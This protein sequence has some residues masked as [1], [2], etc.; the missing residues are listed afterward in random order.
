MIAPERTENL[1]WENPTPS[2]RRG[3]F[4]LIPWL[5][6]GA[7][8]LRVNSGLDR[9]TV[10]LYYGLLT[11]GSISLIMMALWEPQLIDGL[12]KIKPSL[13]ISFFAVCMAVVIAVF[14]IGNVISNQGL[15]ITSMPT[16]EFA[17]Y[18]MFTIFLV[19][20][21]ETLVF[22]F[23]IPKMATLTL[24]N[25]RFEV[26]AGVTSQLTFGGFHFAT[27][28]QSS[29]NPIAAMMS[30]VMLGIVFYIVV[31]L[32]DEWGLG[33]AMGLHAGY[34]ISL[35]FFS[36]GLTTAVAMALSCVGVC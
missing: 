18:L 2:K 3:Y 13:F 36:G 7:M 24:R 15:T 28:T 29:G 33:A 27:Y 35:V 9:D 17:N 20:P 5:L 30:A 11:G 21:I 1:L 16:A 19:A 32:S 8:W 25:L 26:A 14:G 10:D 31:R 12:K 34:N 6:I 23:I 4:L 22:Q